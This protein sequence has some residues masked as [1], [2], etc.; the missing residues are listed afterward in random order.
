MSSFNCKKCGTPNL[1]SGAAGELV[2]LLGGHADVFANQEHAE[3]QAYSLMQGEHGQSK[4]IDI[5]QRTFAELNHDWELARH[6]YNS[7]V[8]PADRW[9]VAEIRVQ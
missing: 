1:D 2:W 4:L 6:Y 8:E 9:H 5:Q 7:C 3:D